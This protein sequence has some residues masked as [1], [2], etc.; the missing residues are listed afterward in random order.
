MKKG[1][2]ILFIFIAFQAFS[3]KGKNGWIVKSVLE[4]G[5]MHD[6]SAKGSF[7]YLSVKQ[8]KFS[9]SIGC[10]KF[11]GRLEF[12]DNSQIHPITLVKL[13]ANCPQEL[14]RLD[15]AVMEAINLADKL[16]MKDNTAEF[17]N[18]D[19]LVLLLTK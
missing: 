6:V 16:I 10:N 9:G 12:K 19:R 14:D 18:V 7:F 1:L 15:Y 4:G 8:K 5:K 17:Y 3:Q 11:K 2:S 13:K